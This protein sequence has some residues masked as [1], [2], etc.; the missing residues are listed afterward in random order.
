VTVPGALTYRRL[1]GRAR[2]P[3]G[4]DTLWVGEDHLLLVELRGFTETYRRFY[5]RDVQAIILR[6]TDR[7]ATVGILLGV[8]GLVFVG[9]ATGAGPFWNVF[10]GGVSGL[11]FLGLALNVA[12]G[13]TC[14]CVLRTAL[15]T[16]TLRS[17][18]RLRRARSV[19]GRLRPHIEL[20]Q[21]T[22]TPEDILARDRAAHGVETAAAPQPIAAVP[23]LSPRPPIVGREQVL[24]HDTG[25]AH[26]L[27]AYV[28]LFSAIAVVVPVLYFHLVLS[29][30]LSVVFLGR[31]ACLVAALARQSRS[32][33]PAPVK[34][35]AWT[36]FGFEIAIMLL[37]LITGSVMVFKMLDSGVLT[38]T[39][40][41]PASPL[42]IME[43]VQSNPLYKV[44][45]FVSSLI[46]LTLGVRGLLLHRRLISTRGNRWQTLPT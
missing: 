15:Q 19:I 24:R 39:A 27:L 17:L 33:L 42:A 21:G 8:L 4:S 14:S 5:F 16:V 32:D 38:P 31:M 26:E 25:R 28:L 37:G 12:L 7:A 41:T 6:R 3:L 46:W 11:L 23:P 35:F 45:A 29:L 30:V 1:P 18:G 43:L 10:W 44:S 36:A 9:V 22:L 40:S 13:P 20:A 34:T 2:T